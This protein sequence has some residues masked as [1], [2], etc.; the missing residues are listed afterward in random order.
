VFDE[1]YILFHFNII[2]KTTGCPLLKKQMD[3]TWQLQL[4]LYIVWF[5]A[6]CFGLTRSNHQANKTQ[7]KLLRKLRTTVSLGSPSFANKK[8]PR[9]AWKDQISCQKMD[10]GWCA[11]VLFN[12]RNNVFCV[13][14]CLLMVSC[15][16][17]KCC[18]KLCTVQNT[19][20]VRIN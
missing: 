7:N 4:F 18:F 11:V 9:S 14:F 10:A 17:E 19:A 12:L 13:L 3:N 8:K 20:H 1:V 15:W 6:T 16:A 2:L 5:N